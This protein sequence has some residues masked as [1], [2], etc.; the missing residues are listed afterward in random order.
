MVLIPAGPSIPAFYMDKYEVTNAQ[1]RKFV[2]ATGHR[3][4]SYW[5]DPKFNQSNQPVVGVSWHDAT[6]YAKWAGKRL[7]REAEWEWAARG[8]LKGKEYSW[9]DDQSLARDYANREGI[10]G[11]DRWEYCAPVGSFKPNRYG[12]YDMAG[13][14]FEWCQN[15][16]DS[17]QKYRVSRGGSWYANAYRLRVA[18]RFSYGPADRY[19]NFGFRC[20]SGSDYP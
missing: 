17:R 15:W 19:S 14:A 8:G 20:V 1:Y 2:Q 4:P 10:G 13:N 7:P 3:E 9:G 5:N 16:Y 6:A 18:N 12:L 11:K